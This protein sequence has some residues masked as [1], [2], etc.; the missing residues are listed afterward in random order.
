MQLPRIRL[1][2]RGMM[3]VIAVIGATLGLIE[4]RR[5]RFARI[6]NAHAM[7]RVNLQLSE[8]DVYI[9]TKAKQI[10]ED[11]SPSVLAAYER[12]WREALP[13]ARFVEHHAQMS[14]KYERASSRPWLP[15]ATDPPAPPRPTGAYLKKL[16]ASYEL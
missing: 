15:V 7:E 4:E 1:S 3:L 12:S 16:L 13:L 14:E 2:L 5:A 9:I 10:G 6:A 8:L 11:R